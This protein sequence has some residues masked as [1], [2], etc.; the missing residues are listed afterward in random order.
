MCH[1]SHVMCHVSRVM[2]H[3]SPVTCHVSFFVVDKLVEL[4]NGGSVAVAVGVSDR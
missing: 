4:V 2:C 1:V 3:V